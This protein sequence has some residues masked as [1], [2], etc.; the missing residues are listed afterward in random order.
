MEINIEAELRTGCLGET[1]VS[2]A[3]PGVRGNGIHWETK[4]TPQQG[5]ESPALVLQTMTW[6]SR[7]N[8]HSLIPLFASTYVCE[9]IF[10][11]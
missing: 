10:S 1:D 5:I 9:K 6:Q 7:I 11:D 8:G 4:Q 3:K 2:S